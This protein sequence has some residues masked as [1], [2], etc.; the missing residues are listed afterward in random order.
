MGATPETVLHNHPTHANQHQSSINLHQ[1]IQMTIDDK[2]RIT[3]T[4]DKSLKHEVSLMAAKDS[5]DVSAEI[6]VLVREA[7]GTR[8]TPRR[9][10]A[11]PN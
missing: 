4:I 9:A 7:I 8:K 3:I 10:M 1:E 11:S 5:R 6:C 2:T